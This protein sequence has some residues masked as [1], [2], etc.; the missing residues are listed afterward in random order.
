M[1]TNAMWDRVLDPGLLTD[2]SGRIDEICIG[3]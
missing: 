2:L 3:L 1:T